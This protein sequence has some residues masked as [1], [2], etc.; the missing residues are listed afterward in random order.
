MKRLDEQLC[1]QAGEWADGLETDRGTMAYISAPPSTSN[2]TAPIPKAR[3]YRN[4]FR[5]CRISPA[6]ATQ[7][8]TGG[9]AAADMMLGRLVE[10][11]ATHW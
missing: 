2:R 4:E 8:R 6:C 5:L 3:R 10:S 1:Q 9:M 11:R 7:F